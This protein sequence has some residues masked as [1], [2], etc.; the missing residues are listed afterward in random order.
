VNLSIVIPVRRPE[1]GKS[2]LAPALDEADRA[3]LVKRMFCHVLLVAT[4]SV[5]A[6]RCHVVSQSPLL[7]NLAAAAGAHAVRET[8]S[9]LNAALEQAAALVDREAPVLALSADLPLLASEDIAALAGELR[10]A[11]VVVATDRAGTG[12]NALLLRETGMIPYAFGD[13]SLARHK[14]AAAGKG[15][16]FAVIRRPR[17]AADVDHP[18]DLDLLLTSQNP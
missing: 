7:L 17:L 16:R 15:L 18:A 1:L 8:G 3:A 14:A 5:L 9:G 2:R 6:D 4:R 10:N 11:D 12:T 13:A